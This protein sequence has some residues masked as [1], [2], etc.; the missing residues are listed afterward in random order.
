MEEMTKKFYKTSY[1]SKVKEYNLFYWKDIEQSFDD[2]YI[3]VKF[4]REDNIKNIEEI[5]KLETEYFKEV[6]I[7]PFY[8][9]IIL[10]VFCFLLLTTFLVIFLITKNKDIFP[11]FTIPVSLLIVA[12]VSYSFYRINKFK[13]DNLINEDSKSKILSKLKELKELK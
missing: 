7:L 5:K 13:K 3:V 4:I 12:S 8:P 6:K 1:Q 11:Y 10:T 9:I 2:E